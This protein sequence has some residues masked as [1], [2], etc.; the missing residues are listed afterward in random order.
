MDLGLEDLIPRRTLIRTA[1][2][3]ML[4]APAAAFAQPGRAGHRVAP[5]AA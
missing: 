3:V 2:A 4:A 1:G 5:A